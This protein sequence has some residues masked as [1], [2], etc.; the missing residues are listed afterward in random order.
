MSGSTWGGIAGAAIGFVVTG[1]N[2]TGAYWGYVIG[3]GIGSYLDPMT[4]Q[5]QQFQNQNIQGSQSGMARG[6]AFATVTVVGN[7]LD[8]EDKP[9]LGT[10]TEDAGKGGAEI[11]HDT[12]LLSYSIEICDSSELRGTTVN[13]VLAV[14]EDEKLVY[15][16][17]PGAQLPWADSAKW[18]SNKTFHHGGEDQEPSALLEGIH[19]ADN[20]PAYRGTLRMDVDSEDLM[21]HGQRLPTYRFLVS[22]CAGVEP[23]VEN[24]SWIVFESSYPG[25]RYSNGGAFWDISSEY[26]DAAGY[27]VASADPT[28]QNRVYRDGDEVLVVGCYTDGGGPGVILS[29]NGFITTEGWGWGGSLRFPTAA[30][31]GGTWFVGDG[32]DGIYRKDGGSWTLIPVA[33]GSNHCLGSDG[34]RLYRFSGDTFY[35]IST[36]D[37]STLQTYPAIFGRVAMAGASGKCVALLHRYAHDLSSTIYE[38]DAGTIS[39]HASPFPTGLISSE[40]G[41]IGMHYSQAFSL[42]VATLQNRLAYGTSAASLTLS[43]YV[44]PNTIVGVDDDGEKFIVA[45]AG[46]TLHS[47]T[48]LVS[49]TTVFD[50]S[51][52]A[53]PMS[54]PVGIAAVSVTY[55]GVAIPD[56]DGYYTDTEGNLIGPSLAETNG[57]SLTLAEVCRRMYR[58]GAP[59]LTPD[60]TVLDELEPF[61]VRGY[62]VQ[63]TSATV[64]AALEPLRNIFTFDLPEHDSAIRARLRGGPID[65]VVNPDDIIEGEESSIN[66]KRG[67][68]VE[69]PRKLHLSYLDPALDFKPTT[70]TAERYSPDVR[71]FGEITVNAQLVMT[72]DEAAQA[73]DKM[74]KVIWTERE[75]EQRFS[76]PLDYVRLVPSDLIALNGRRYRVDALR[77]EDGMVVIER[78]AY[79]RQSAYGSTVT[80]VPSIPPPAPNSSVR[81]PTF[82]AVMNLPALRA[83]DDRPGIYVAGNGYLS[84]W[85]GARIDLSRDGGTSYAT[86]VVPDTDGCVMGVLTAALPEA[87]AEFT[88]TENTLS[89][90]LVGNGSLE[91]ATPL[92]VLNGANAAAILY[93]DGTVEIIQFQIAT[94]ITPRKYDLTTLQRGRLDTTTGSHAIGAKFVLLSSAL[95]FVPL[96]AADLG[97]TITIR[98]VSLGTNPEANDSYDITLATMESQREWSVTNVAASRDGSNNVTVT[99]DGRPRFGTNVQPLHSA[100]FVGYRVTYSDG[101]T[102]VAKNVARTPLVIVAGIVETDEVTTHTY[103]AAEQTTDFGSVPG[104]LTITIAAMNDITG[105]GPT[106]STSA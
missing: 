73:A 71:V 17:R 78:A 97:Q 7:L 72:A 98:T 35:R 10:R 102:T 64:S 26:I 56:A 38:L 103:T 69:F 76:L 83:D 79:D 18:K 99:W 67:Q 77:I 85:A 105:T 63:D 22:V 92:Q 34:T 87:S 59:Q 93:A 74:L 2:P 84:G 1:F 3:A 21:P 15:D 54:S 81:G 31:C 6:V 50:S 90:Q 30:R 57:C 16:V 27:G 46:G 106:E 101:V 20:V 88:D 24:V 32:I 51:T 70:Q 82:T 65:V 96:T 104:S 47:A 55:T 28:L 53:Y 36:T 41:G 61:N 37:G 62:L 40:S 95:R 11:E 13:H 68:A 44:F 14:W 86:Q 39:T 33:V 23:P 25:L 91:T 42:L 48:D 100:H 8:G 75:D 52:A 45:C 60:H 66:G 9:R 89:V 12:A 19:G 5:G 43:S 4:V 49:F 80:G 94:E 58:I 29:S